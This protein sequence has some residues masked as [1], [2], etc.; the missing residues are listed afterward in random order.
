MVAKSPE[1]WAW[2]VGVSRDHRHLQ[3]NLLRCVCLTQAHNVD[4]L[5]SDFVK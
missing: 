5:C 1:V 4:H 3:R 2:L